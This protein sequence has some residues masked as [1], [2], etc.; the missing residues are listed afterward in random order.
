[1]ISRIGTYFASLLVVMICVTTISFAQKA[2]P[3]SDAAKKVESIVFKTTELKN[4]LRNFGRT[5]KLNVVFDE[6]VRN[7]IIDVELND[8]TVAAAMKIILI[9]QRLA[10]R[11]IED[12]TIII[13]VDN[14]ANNQRYVEFKRWTGQIEE[15]K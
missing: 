6:T 7:N 5:L 11:I 13:F 14:P 1:M 4:V 3:A 15:K 2:A 10:A 8:V 12:N 9:Q